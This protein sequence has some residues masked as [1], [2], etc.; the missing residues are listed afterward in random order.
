MYEK[1]GIS[2]LEVEGSLASEDLASAITKTHADKE[3]RHK[4]FI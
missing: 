3:V 4:L 2:S 1:P